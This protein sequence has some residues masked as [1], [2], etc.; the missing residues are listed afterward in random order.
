MAQA[1]EWQTMVRVARLYY[2]DGRT[3]EEIAEAL[4]VSRPRVSRLLKQARECGIVQIQVVD[5]TS[6][7]SELE[8]K[9]AGAF[10]LS[11]AIVVAHAGGSQE[12]VRARLGHAAARHLEEIVVHG[13]IVGIGSGR[14]LQAMATALRTSRKVRATFV[15]L[16]GGLQQV[17]GLFQAN[18]LARR[19][20]EAFAAESLQL[21]TPA[22]LADRQARDTVLASSPVLDVV[23]MWEGLTVAVVGIG[24]VRSRPGFPTLF[25][26]Y[27]DPATQQRLVGEGAV[28]GICLRYFTVEGNPCEELS[29]RIAG[30]DLD[31]LRRTSQVVGVAGG[32]EK[33]EA[34]LGALRGGYVKTLVTDEDTAREV[35]EEAVRY[36]HAGGTARQDGEHSVREG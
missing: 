9:L 3:Q 25:A 12:L 31:R 29:G 35:L 6:T 21:Y 4:G 8:R 30:L 7:N 16:L 28:G 20:A 2:E 23:K 18:E 13:D 33:V 11:R 24:N 32:T 27:L 17:P 1:E 36:Q 14:T 5:P 22:V 26:N 15:P 19:A 10:A 34:V